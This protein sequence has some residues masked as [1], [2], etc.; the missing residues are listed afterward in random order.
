ML[1]NSIEFLIF[2]PLVVLVYYMIPKRI[3]HLWLLVAS[4]YF[5]MSWN[6]KYALLI[7]TST[8][9][10]YISGLLIDKTRTASW[11]TDRK[12]MFSKLIV[13]ASLTSNLGILFFFKYFNF[14]VD[15]IVN[16]C[17]IFNI[18]ITPLPHFDIVLP[19][20][21]SFYT[22]QALSYT[23]DVYRGDIYAENNFFRYALFVSFFP[24]LVA[25][26]IERSK[27]LLKQLA[28]PKAFSFN[29][30]RDGLLLMLWGYFLKIVLADRIAIFVDTIYGNYS[31]YPGVYLIIATVL[32]SIQIYCDFSGYSTIAMGAA[33][34]LGIDLMKN[35]D[36][37]YLSTSV[38]DFWRQW[39]I[40]LT[41][42]FKDYLYIPLGGSRKGKLRKYINKMIVFLISGLWHG[43]SWSFVVWGG[44]NGIYQVLGEIL[45]PFRDKVNRILRLDRDSLS[46]KLFCGFCTFILV[47]F[48][49]IFFRT[50]IT[51]AIE[52]IK[53][54]FTAKNF[55]I[56]FDGS[57]YNCGLPEKDFR[58]MLIAIFVLVFSDI[59]MRKQIVVRDVIQKQEYWFRWLF[60]AFAVIAIL[61]FGIW[62]PN[63]NAANFIYFQF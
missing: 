58:L 45:Q 6:A 32:F 19:V 50:D 7:L 48:S 26:P 44:L 46:H 37:P 34:I 4:Y 36:A 29:N 35:F 21:I 59:C 10:T 24:Q 14:A 9:I 57:L 12:N 31:V 61:T 62:G 60:I 3:K 1:F 2:F 15:S 38:A 5:Y 56:L 13:F 52:V 39:H 30:A 33:K 63:Y 53:S 54:I 49:W 41:S 27:N 25:G 28:V 11:S 22:F 55:W 47:D 40:S 16:I 23:I 20:G 43:A 51:S 42:W 8:F 18:K 17:N